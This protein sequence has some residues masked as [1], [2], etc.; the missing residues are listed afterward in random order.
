M[1]VNVQNIPDYCQLGNRLFIVD[2]VNE[3][4][5]VDGLNSGSR[6]MGCEPQSSALSP[7]L[8]AGIALTPNASYVYGVRRILVAGDLE[9][10][11]ATKTATVTTGL[12]QMTCGAAGASGNEASDWQSIADAE[13][14]V[15]FNG[16]TYSVTAIDCSAS[17]ASGQVASMADVASRIQTAV[18]SACSS[19][20]QVAWST[21]RF[22]FSSAVGRLQYLSAVS[23]GSGTDVHGASYLNGATGTAVE[24][25]LLYCEVT[26]AD[27]EEPPGADDWW[28]VKYQVLRS[29]ANSADVLYLVE[30]LTQTQYDALSSGVYE[31]DTADS[32]LN[33]AV[34]EDLSSVQNVRF[35]PVRCIRSLNGCLVGAGSYTYDMG[36]VSGT[37]GTALLTVNAPGD[38]SRADI[39]AF[40]WIE[41]EPVVYQVQSVNVST[42]V[43]TLSAN[44]TNTVDGAAW[45]K[46]HDFETIFVSPPIPENIEGYTAGE[47]I[48]GNSGDGDSIKALAAKNHVG[49]VFGGSRVDLL[50]RVSD[51]WVLRAH[52]GTPPGCV[53]S[54]SVADRWAD[55]VYYYAGD[56]GVWRLSASLAENIG[57]NIEPIFRESVDHSMDEYC[58]AVFDPV[59]QLYMLWVFEWG[60]ESLGTRCPQTCLVYD[61]SLKQ[62]YKFELAAHSSGILIDEDGRPVVSVGC[63][64]S[65]FEL[66]DDSVD[67]ADVLSVVTSAGNSW[68]EVSD[69][70]SSVVSGQPVHVISNVGVVQRRIVSYVEGYRAYVYGEWD[71]NPCAGHTAQFGAIRWHWT[72]AELSSDSQ[73][74]GGVREVQIL[75]NIAVLHDVE[76]ESTPVTISVAAIGKQSERLIQESRDWSND[77]D[78]D[79]VRGAQ[80]GLRSRR[81]SV[82]I[83]GARGPA[84]ILEIQADWQAATKAR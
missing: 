8:S 1:L 42:R 14:A 51:T 66:S 57:A 76:T 47:E 72:S 48:V 43:L 11:S 81:S 41:D 24:S 59:R 9:V 10:P 35:P 50:Q 3:N 68:I 61:V 33:T 36:T 62:W 63:G 58:H 46:W 19:A 2:G 7:T 37:T 53:S 70:I 22:V 27:Y 69:D 13:F 78:L 54:A 52:P 64:A 23:G 17:H 55:A 21:D 32:A 20:I 45:S 34:S 40:V 67:G 60:W 84:K 73:G 82:T 80:A 56:R 79:E 5:V 71:N 18:Q 74:H 83:S 75:K 28:S 38:V 12:Y 26:L 15:L 49:F 4:Q 25:N 6:P 39:G 16:T 29:F 77:E 65:T 44:L 31:D 30:E